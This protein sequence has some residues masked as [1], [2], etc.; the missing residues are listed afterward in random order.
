MS[1]LLP[2]NGRVSL[3]DYNRC[4]PNP[5]KATK[6]LLWK[7]LCPFLSHFCCFCVL[8]SLL[9]TSNLS[10]LSSAEFQQ[11]KV[12]AAAAAKKT[13]G[14]FW[15]FFISKDRKRRLWMNEMKLKVGLF[16]LFRLKSGS[17]IVG[18]STKRWWRPV[19]VRFP[20]RTCW[21]EAK[22][23]ARRANM[24]E[25]RHWC[26]R[27]RTRPTLRRA[28]CLLRWGR[29]RA[30]S[31]WATTAPASA[32]AATL[33]TNI[34]TS[35]TRTT[36]SI[37]NTTTDSTDF[38]GA[39]TRQRLVQQGTCPRREA[40]TCRRRPAPR[41]W[42]SGTAYISRTSSRRRTWTR[43]PHTGCSRSTRG[44]KLQ[45][46]IWAKDS[47]HKLSRF[48]TWKTNLVL[49]KNDLTYLNRAWR[50]EKRTTDNNPPPPQWRSWAGFEPL[51]VSFVST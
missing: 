42:T 36:S 18:R 12:A 24:A 39:T 23:R 16:F 9:L 34:S 19:R 51:T 27:S 50:E 49:S 30:T 43:G 25:A 32:V 33:T 38:P 7:Q 37:T 40:I 46:T 44:I 1:K 2:N 47:S 48:G 45:I 35:I 5:K 14:I 8:L 15:A 17:K 10:R 20:L 41:R 31:A 6:V 21:P 11:Q 22:C 13:V 29:A 3:V 28:R 26:T 4:N